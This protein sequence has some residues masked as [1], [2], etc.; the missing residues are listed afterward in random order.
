MNSRT[1]HLALSAVWVLF[2]AAAAAAFVPRWSPLPFLALL[3]AALVALALV[4]ETGP[5]VLAAIVSSVVMVGSGSRLEEATARVLPMMVAAGWAGLFLVDWFK[6]RNV[7]RRRSERNAREAATEEARILDREIGFYESRAAGLSQ[8]AEIRRRLSTAAGQLGAVLEP[9]G[10]QERLTSIAGNLFTKADVTLSTPERPE[11]AAAPVF[12][13]GHA[14]LVEDGDGGRSVM[15]AP[16]RLARAVVGALVVKAPANT[17]YGRDD[18]RLLDVLTGLASEALA[19]AELFAEV[20]QNALRDNLTGLL[21]HR[22]FQDHLEAAILEASRYRQPVSVIMADIDHFKSVNDTHGHQAGDAVLQGFSH[23]LDRNVRDV[24]VVAR[25]GGEEFIVLLYQTPFDQAAQIAEA[26][27]HELSELPFDIGGR[28]LS[29]TASFGVA[30]FPE[31]ATS[32]QQLLR[33]ADQ[34]LYGAK[35]AGRNRVV[36]RT[37]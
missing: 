11:P 31:D 1:S 8:R 4:G 26:M 37:G 30:S 27:R 13:D 22:A 17:T 32:A 25:Y 9:A 35:K 21:T 29:V 7:D 10:I 3:P 14:R 20:H 12:R 15:A 16:V 6:R 28:R 2:A 33:Q 36:G 19:N 18:L 24:D 34:R 5:A 23:V